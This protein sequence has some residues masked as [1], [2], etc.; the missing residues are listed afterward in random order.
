MILFAAQRTLASGDMFTFGDDVPELIDYAGGG[1]G[2]E[3]TS[4]LD[5]ALML[6]FDRVVPGHGNVT[7]KQAMRKFRDNTLTL[8]NRVHDLLVQKKTKTDV[9]LMLRN[10]FHFADLHIARSLDG[11]MVEMQ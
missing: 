7:D 4:T 2:K 3:W 9:E 8:R 11:L 5:S 1:S 6:D 10:E